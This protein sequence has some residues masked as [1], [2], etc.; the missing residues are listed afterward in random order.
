MYTFI[1]VLLVRSAS[2]SVCRQIDI[3][4]RNVKQLLFLQ[5]KNLKHSPQSHQT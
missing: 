2:L 3:A 5:T 4:H 1:L